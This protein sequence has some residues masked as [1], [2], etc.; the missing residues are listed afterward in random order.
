MKTLSM[1]AKLILLALGIAMISVVV[2]SVGITNTYNLHESQGTMYERDLLGVAKVSE[3]NTKMYNIR[4]TIYGFLMSESAAE[5][6]AYMDT[7]DKLGAEFSGLLDEYLEI[8]DDDQARKTVDAIKA[9]FETYK[10]EYGQGMHMAD[11]GSGS[12][13]ILAFLKGTA[14]KTFNER[15]GPNIDLLVKQ[16]S[17]SAAAGYRAATAAFTQALVVIIAVVVLGFILSV[18][19]A[20]FIARGI[21]RPISGIVTNL[22]E[23]SSQIA[24][25]SSQLSDSSQEIANGA[26]EQAAGIE[27]TTASIEELTSMVKQNLENAKQASLLSEKATE[28]SQDGSA[29][30]ELMSGA[31]AA[32]SKSTEEIKTVIDVIDDIAFQTNML[33]LNAA[34]E[35]ARAGEAGMG[36][37]VVAD[38]V[39]NL[40]NRSS[41]S[42][43]ETS[44][45]IKATLKNVEE[46]MG[47]SKALSEIFKEILVNS[48]KV[49]EM[50]KEVE[51]ASAQQD[52]GISQVNKAIIQFDSVVQANASSAEETASAAEEMQG[53]V[54]TLKDVVV[55]LYRLVTGK[56]YTEENQ[57][58][59]S[60]S[61]AP[62]R[63]IAAPA[64]APSS[65]RIEAARRPG[66]P[67]PRPDNQ[68]AHVISFEDDEEFRA[69]D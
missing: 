30:M 23:S 69:E 67:A 66:K 57:A 2:G 12:G 58:R 1:N 41:E 48:R 38:E 9:G 21:S 19:M 55:E 65:G 33:A 62:S 56:A 68:N 50:T 64:R 47:I 18:T 31:M 4:I 8:V 28:A 13:E 7:L 32:I 16:S 49:L 34:V 3:V 46:G 37:A 44:S 15:V 60:A 29:Q 35:A 45:M 42:A 39:K 17:E 36:F 26:S 14:I 22:S 11:K 5:R 24:V 61:K 63:R 53:Q 51:S 59:A 20:V 43:K 25:S 6:D 52:V 27:E 54:G 40:A 10:T